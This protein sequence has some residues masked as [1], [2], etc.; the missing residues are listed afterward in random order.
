MSGKV[1]KSSGYFRFLD[2]FIVVLFL[3]IAALSLDLFRDD[4]LYT[5]NLQNVQPVGTVVVRKNTVQRRHSDRV[6]W[7]RLSYE[8]PVYIGDLIRVAE[9]SA[10]TLKLEGGSVDLEENTLI[11][12]M[13]SADGEGLHIILSEGNLSLSAGIGGKG[14]SLDVNGKQVRAA[15]GTVFSAASGTDGRISVSVNQGSV[16][17][18]D[19]GRAA[20]EISSGNLIAMNSD[21]TERME[22]AAVV[23]QPVPNARYLKNTP[24]PLPINFSWNRINLA[25]NETLRM[26]IASDRNFTRDLRTIENL[27]SQAQ[28]R[29]NAG[30]WFWRL[31]FGNTVL[32]SGR[33]TVAD[34]SG[35]RLESPAANSLFRYRDELPVLNFQWGEVEEAVSYIIEVCDTPDFANPRI[36]REGSASFMIDSSLGEGTW[37]WRV[38]PIFPP[39]FS[40]RSGFSTPSSFRIEQ[41]SFDP[42]ALEGETDIA[43]WF[44]SQSAFPFELPREN[45]PQIILISPEQGVQIAGLTALRQQTVFRWDID[46][47]TAGAEITSSKFILS[48]NANPLQG[49]PIRVI[50]NPP[51]TVRIDRLGVGTWYWTVELE[52]SDGLTVN[53]PPRRITVQAIPL[54]PAP[55]NLQP[56]RQTNFDQ[57]ELQSL[58][59]IVFNWSAVRGANA[60]IFTLYQQT[61]SGRRQILNTTIRNGARSYTLENLRVLDRGIFIWQVEAVNIGRGSAIEQR[62]RAAENTFALD[63]PYPGPVQIEDTGILYGN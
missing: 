4:L 49:Q 11:R 38:M 47:E 26:E 17:F 40:G 59:A 1:K 42:A 30:L 7:D 5:I 25:P 27:N 8:S 55:Q 57:E 44:A 46:A 35:V 31:S 15:P 29:F 61:T 52:T 33:F 50:Q 62:G 22:R 19:E 45:I 13:R 54:L 3:S 24:E 43:R 2:F 28:A 37:Y 23:V 10:A 16:R 21:G 41:V 63:F 14:V 58:R 6:L 18:L 34:A 9:I 32:S 48:G 53:A 20:R 39:V 36:R 60:Y 56:A 12:I 51:R